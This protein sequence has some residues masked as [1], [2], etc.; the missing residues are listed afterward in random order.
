MDG[1]LVA[2]IL[3]LF[4]IF[5]GSIFVVNRIDNAGVQD[6]SVEM[7]QAELPIVYVRYHD[8]FINTLHGYTGKVDTTYF[9]DT[10]TPMD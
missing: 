7:E 8:Q 1:R 6:V 3:I 2:K 9:R 5:I 10:I 4:A